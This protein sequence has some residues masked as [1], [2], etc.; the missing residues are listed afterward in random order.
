[1]TEYL[2]PIAEATMHATHDGPAVS[3]RPGMADRRRMRFPRSSGGF[4]DWFDLDNQEG[5]KEGSAASTE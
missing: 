1:M 2:A 3:L 4:K 5:R